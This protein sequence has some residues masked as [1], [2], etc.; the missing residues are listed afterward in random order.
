MHHPSNCRRWLTVALLCAGLALT[1]CGQKGGL[2]LP[3]EPTPAP[4]QQ[5]EESDDNKN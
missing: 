4:Q 2:Y 1:A 3:D 5:P